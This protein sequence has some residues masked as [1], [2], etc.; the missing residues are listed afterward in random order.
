MSR[1]WRCRRVSKGVQCRTLNLARKRKCVECGKPKPA[2][3]APKHMAAL[4]ASYEEW[5]VLNGGERCGI[6]GRPPSAVRRLDRDHCHRTGLK[7]GLLCARCNRALPAWITPDWL[8]QAI[9]YL[10]EDR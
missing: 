5:I 1:Y 8:R 3:R 4:K 7:R 9:R 6:C 2:K 10:E